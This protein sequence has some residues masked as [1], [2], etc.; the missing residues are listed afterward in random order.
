MSATQPYTAVILVVDD[1]EP[2]LLAIDT[3]LQMAGWN[4]IVT[5]SDSRKVADILAAKPV[6]IVLLDLNM[7]HINGEEL[8][9]QIGRQNPDIPVVVVTGAVEIE[10]AV[11]C[12]K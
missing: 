8:L 9:S 2:I 7:P 1:E 6:D 12:M 4:H 5:C 10:T 11:R 3:T